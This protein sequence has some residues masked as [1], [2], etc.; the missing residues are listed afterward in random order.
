M[1][2]ITKVTVDTLN[3]ALER[4]NDSIEKLN[5]GG[6]QKGHLES[7]SDSE[8]EQV[9]GE[10]HVNKT[11]VKTIILGLVHLKRLDMC[12]E[13]SIKVYKVRRFY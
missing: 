3:I 12:T 2:F 1:N 8:I 5:E 9:I 11:P 7:F 6:V 13:N 4:I 10:S